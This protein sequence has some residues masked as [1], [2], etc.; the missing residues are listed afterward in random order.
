MG[1]RPV[2]VVKWTYLLGIVH[3]TTFSNTYHSPWNTLYTNGVKFKTAVF[4]VEYVWLT[5][6][7]RNVGK[8]Q[9]DCTVTHSRRPP[10]E[11]QKWRW[12]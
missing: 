5:R 9:Q 12:Q 8:H 2:A 7:L 6:L 10:I 3:T 11:T 4:I 1:C